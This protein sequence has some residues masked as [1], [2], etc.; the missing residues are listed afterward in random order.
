MDVLLTLVFL[1]LPSVS[2]GLQTCS[3]GTETS[4]NQIILDVSTTQINRLGGV[5]SCRLTVSQINT[6]AETDVEMFPNGWTQGCDTYMTIPKWSTG[7]QC[8]NGVVQIPPAQSHTVTT[9]DEVRILVVALLPGTR[10]LSGQLQFKLKSSLDL[11]N[12]ECFEPNTNSSQTATS[13]TTSPAGSTD[14]TWS[15]TPTATE[16][17][18]TTGQPSIIYF[19][20]GIL[21]AG[22][23]T[24]AVLV[25]MACGTYVAISRRRRRT[26]HRQK[27]AANDIPISVV[28]PTY[29]G[30]TSRTEEPNSIYDTIDNPYTSVP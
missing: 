7:T 26:S 13:S 10:G 11:L 24:V 29:S 23:A 15:T 28:H 27:P 25:V 6:G 3:S 22:L 14:G 9:D 21:A 19:P 30:L 18:K 17:P 16:I 20:V 1:S 12:I 8:T 2:S 4:S 5:C